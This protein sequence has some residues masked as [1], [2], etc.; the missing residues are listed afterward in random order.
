MSIIKLTS[1]PFLD[2]NYKNV[3]D[4]ESK[5]NQVNYFESRVKREE[6]VNIKYD[7]ERQYIDLK[8]E[9][10]LCDTF[11]YLFYTDRVGK[12]W[13]YFI[14]NVEYITHNNTRIYLKLDVWQTYQFKYKLLPSFVDRCHVPRWNG[15]IPT[16]NLE[17]EG[18]EIG[19]YI[20]IATPEKI[21]SMTKSIVLTSSVPIG[22]VDKPYIGGGSDSDNSGESWKNGKLSAKGFRFIK[23]FEGFAPQKYQDSG[24]YWTIAYGVTLHGEKDIYNMLVGE[25]PITEQRGAEISY[26]LKNSRYGSKIL[27]SVKNLGCNSQNQFDALCSLAYNCGTGVIIGNNSLTEAI[28]KNPTDESTIRPIWENFRI[29]SNGHVLNGLKARRKQ[30][31]NLYFGYDVEMRT[32]STI[33]ADGSINGVVTEN[34]GNGWLPSTPNNT[35]NDFN[36]YKSF[37]NEFGVGWLC[38]VKNGKVTSKYGWRTHPVT[39][40]RKFHHGTDISIGH[41]E[42]T[43]AS[44][45]GI[46]SE[47]GYNDS[48]GYYIYLDC[49]DYRVK[50]MHLS[51]ILVSEGQQV[52]KGDEIGKIGNTGTS[53]GS[54]SHWEIRNIITNEST[55]P[56]PTLQGGDTV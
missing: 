13:F 42:P 1:L 32:I 17:D 33:G 5:Q 36:G 37:N 24:G 54:H 31:C 52:K 56:A 26:N 29:T 47:T 3:L 8:I 22:L 10:S 2:I 21:C 41:G 19:E 43:V 39:N 34:G 55:D 25:S 44:K 48:M 40:E 12:Y 15:D 20:Q 14:T 35:N 53:T 27:S 11:D 4:F 46:I 49:G 30:E 9:K 45:D 23:G 51:K 28:A 7:G 16:Y 6:E 50:Y 38:P 18:I